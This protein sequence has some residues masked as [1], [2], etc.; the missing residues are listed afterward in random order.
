[1]DKHGNALPEI[2]KTQDWRRTHVS[3]ALGYLI[4]REYG[5]M[6][7]GKFGSTYIS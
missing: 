2:D 5:L 7:K 1:M 3:D 6:P 4:E